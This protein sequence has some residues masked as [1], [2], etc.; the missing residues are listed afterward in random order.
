MSLRPRQAASEPKLS[1]AFGHGL[2]PEAPPADPAPIG[3]NAR[4]EGRLRTVAPSPYN[5]RAHLEPKE[6]EDHD[7]GP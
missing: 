1:F 2:L 6:Y 4:D 5:D 7:G 3:K